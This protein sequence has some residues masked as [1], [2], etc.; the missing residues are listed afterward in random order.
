MH[1]KGHISAV[2]RLAMGVAQFAPINLNRLLISP[3]VNFQ[4]EVRRARACEHEQLRCASTVRWHLHIH[5]PRF[6]R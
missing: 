5:E 4:P 1:L 3:R 6:L 2:P